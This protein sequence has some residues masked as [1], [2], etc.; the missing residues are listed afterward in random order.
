M[1]WIG[2]LVYAFAMHTIHKVAGIPNQLD[3][4]DEETEVERSSAFPANQKFI[5]TIMLTSQKA[6]C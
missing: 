3:S 5:D 2:A 4:S 1:H 6:R